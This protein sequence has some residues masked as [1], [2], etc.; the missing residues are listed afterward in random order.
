V[1][2]LAAPNIRT[3]IFAFGGVLQGCRYDKI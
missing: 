3:N 2:S 1:L